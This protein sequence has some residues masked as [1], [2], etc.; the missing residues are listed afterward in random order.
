[1]RHNKKTVDLLMQ[2]R[3]DGRQPLTEI[4]RKISMPV[5]TIFDRVRASS[6]NMIQ[7]FTCLLDFRK[8]GF[9]CRAHMVFRIRKDHRED[10]QALLLR[11]PNVNSVYKINNG[12]DFLVETVFK[13]LREVDEFLEKIDEKFKV[14]EKNV[15]YIIDDIAR[16]RFLTDPVHAEMI[17]VI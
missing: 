9:N 6:G 17:G 7:R 12:Y 13:E 15:Y 14:Q 5:S 1:M 10:M 4:S 8:L 3:K 11:H 16:E 2:L